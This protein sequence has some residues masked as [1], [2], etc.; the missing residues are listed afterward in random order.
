MKHRVPL[1]AVVAVC[2]S[3]LALLA[4]APALAGNANAGDVWVDNVGQ[5]AGPGHEMDPHL[6]CADINLWGSGLADSGGSYTIDGWPPSGSQEQDYASSWSYHGSG[7][8]VI[9]VIS[10][11]ALIRNAVANGDAPVNKQ[12]FHF[13]LQFSQDP[14][15]H[16]TF[17]VDCAVP[18]MTTQAVS[19]TIGEPIHDVAIISGSNAATGTITW[20]VYNVSDSTCSHPLN[21]SPLTTAVDGDGS[22]NSPD[23]TPTTPGTYQW[24]ASYSGDAQNLSVAGRCGD[25]QERSVVSKA[26]PSIATVATSNLIGQPIHDVA[27]LTGGDAPT[28]SI[29]WNLY[30]AGTG[31]ATSLYS[32]AV[33]VNGDGV[34]ETPAHTIGAGSYEWVATYGGDNNNN[35]AASSCTD[36]N[37]QSTVSST[38]TP[39]LSL[40]KLERD[41]ATGS[42]THGPLTGQPGDTIDYQM[43]VVNTGDTPLVITFSD[44][45]CDAGTLSAPKVLDPTFDPATSTLSPGGELQYTCSHVLL[46]GDAPQFTNTAIVTGQ[47]P[48]GPALTRTDGVV[49]L[50][51]TPAMTVQKLQR[52]GSSGSF[53]AGIITAN[54]G[55]TIN[56]EIRVTN[57][58]NTALTL[59]LSDLRCDAGTIHGPA[60]ISGALS[61][62]TL[63]PGGV[64]QYTCSHVLT[65][66]DPSPFTNTATVTGQPPQGPPVT[67]TSS[68]SATKQSLHG[69]AVVK[70]GAGTVKTTKR[71]HGKTVVVCAPK[72]KHKKHKHERHHQG[73]VVVV[74]RTGPSFTG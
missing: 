34:Y 61:G 21:G 46:A 6:A 55:D 10:V 64:A 45:H 71:L 73:V 35:G 23:F 11:S 24:V 68:V 12:G 51:A 67:G 25:P 58:G 9:D 15:K 72:Q 47:P 60:A 48:T 41:G 38:P 2:A 4:A 30:S 5:P 40:I 44:P 36:P 8:K 50:V 69:V 17:W 22:Y 29:T 19:A 70:C 74:R 14:Q 62:D 20:N 65:A 59:S 43:T 33:P 31:C 66:S 7:S 52:D 56:Y 1:R 27:T 26:S 3:A 37:E 57:S 39:G 54:V 18:T 63:S 28:G 13:K 42:F 32:V 53:T 49:A 16:K